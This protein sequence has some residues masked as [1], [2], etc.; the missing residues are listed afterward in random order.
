MERLE[1]ATSGS[2][3]S[4]AVNTTLMTQSEKWQISEE[5]FVRTTLTCKHAAL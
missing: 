3:S 4:Q 2:E 5:K 1:A